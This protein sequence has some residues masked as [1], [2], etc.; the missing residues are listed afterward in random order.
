MSSV[1]YLSIP[2]FRSNYNRITAKYLVSEIYLFWLKLYTLGCISRNTLILLFLYLILTIRTELIRRKNFHWDKERSVDLH[3][4]ARENCL[5][6]SHSHKN[7]SSF[8]NQY[9]HVGVE[10]ETSENY[11]IMLKKIPLNP[12]G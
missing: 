11:N 7:R 5:T 8:M 2:N 3:E 6:C 9:L 1:W 12:Y 4:K 10:K